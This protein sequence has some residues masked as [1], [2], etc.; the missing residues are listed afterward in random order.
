MRAGTLNVPAIVGFG[1]AAELAAQEQ[2]VEAQRLNRLRQQLWQGICQGVEGVHLS[3]PLELSAPSIVHLSF[4]GLKQGRLINALKGL[5]VSTG[6]ACSS[7][8]GKPSY[9]LEALGMGAEQTGNVLRLSLGRFTSAEEID[10]AVSYL[11]ETVRAL[12]A[13]PGRLPL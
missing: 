9:V 2:E 6:S 4:S 5:A 10:A 3:C 8:S 11:V 12:R 13:H 7:G 1:K